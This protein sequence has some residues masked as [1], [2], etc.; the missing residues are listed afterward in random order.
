MVLACEACFTWPRGLE[1]PAQDPHV[2]HA[3]HRR[4][5]YVWG[6]PNMAQ[7]LYILFVVYPGVGTRQYALDV[8]FV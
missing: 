4:S 8:C 5:K 3:L 2:R 6:K 7:S 1:P